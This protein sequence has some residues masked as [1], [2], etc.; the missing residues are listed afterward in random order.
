[1]D[2]LGGLDVSGEFAE[3]PVEALLGEMSTAFIDEEIGC[4]APGYSLSGSGT[5]GG[6]D[7][8]DEGRGTRTQGD[9][10]FGMGFSN[11]YPEAEALCV[12]ALHSMDG[13]VAKFSESHAGES[14][15][16]QG[17]GG[18]GVGTLKCFLDGAVDLRRERFGQLKG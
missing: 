12:G 14:E 1:M 15:Q 4:E 9:D 10:A 13:K 5:A 8:F 3:V 7:L 6:A 17:V 18:D 11:G 2:V 16:Q